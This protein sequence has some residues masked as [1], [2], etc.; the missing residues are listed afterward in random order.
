MFVIKLASGILLGGLCE[1]GR[2]KVAASKRT[3]T[4]FLYP[5]LSLGEVPGRFKTDGVCNESLHCA[6]VHA[7]LALY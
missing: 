4:A 3:S 1:V 5:P 2:K 7:P 6:D